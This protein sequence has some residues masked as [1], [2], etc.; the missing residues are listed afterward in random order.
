M[1]CAHLHEQLDGLRERRDGLLGLLGRPKV[2]HPI[3]TMPVLVPDVPC[4]LICQ[5]PPTPVGQERHSP[6]PFVVLSSATASCQYTF[7]PSQYEGP[8]SRV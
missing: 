1:G 6:V 3:R 2:F 4:T 5:N 7:N 8:A